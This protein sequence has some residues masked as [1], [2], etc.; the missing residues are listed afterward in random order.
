MIHLPDCAMCLAAAARK[1]STTNYT[2]EDSVLSMC[3][4]TLTN[5]GMLMFQVYICRGITI[6]NNDGNAY[7]S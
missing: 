4:R 7:A 6:D 5:G 2:Y 3:V 1:M